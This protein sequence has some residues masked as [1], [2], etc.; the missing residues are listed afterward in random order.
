MLS[1]LLDLEAGQLAAAARRPLAGRAPRSS[2]VVGARKRVTSLRRRRCEGV[3]VGVGVGVPSPESFSGLKR[4]W[5]MPFFSK[6][7]DTKHWDLLPQTYPEDI[8]SHPFFPIL[9]HHS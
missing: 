9:T 2:V 6:K 7:I 8:L 5:R 1:W 4:T 3:G